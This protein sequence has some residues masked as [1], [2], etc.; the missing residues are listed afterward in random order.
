MKFLF[1][2]SFEQR[3][4]TLKHLLRGTLGVH[5]VDLV[6]LLEVVH[7]RLCLGVVHLEPLLHR[8]QVVITALTLLTSLHDS[9]QH[10]L[11]GALKKQ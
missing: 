1:F 6:Q 9:R 5:H 11:F 10:G 7:D 8:L 2:I 4:Q 3:L